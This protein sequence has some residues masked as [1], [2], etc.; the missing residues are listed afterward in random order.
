MKTR[1]IVLDQQ[2]I[3]PVWINE[4]SKKKLSNTGKKYFYE[5]QVPLIYD[6]KI[7]RVGNRIEGK[8]HRLFFNMRDN[9]VF[10]A[11]NCNFTVTQVGPV[12]D[13]LVILVKTVSYFR[14][15]E[16]VFLYKN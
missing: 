15:R 1:V 3:V 4:S 14:L 10:Q 16:R 6:V 9:R 13:S 2:S 12:W 11:R 5:F 7:N 8:N